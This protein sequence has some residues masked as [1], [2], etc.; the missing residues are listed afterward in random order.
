MF[1]THVKI[2][3]VK[4]DI[5][6]DLAPEYG[7]PDENG[8]RHIHACPFFHVG[9]EF[10]FNLKEGITGGEFCEWAK[11]AIFSNLLAVAGQGGATEPG[12]KKDI[13]PHICCCTDGLRPV[14]FKLEVM[15]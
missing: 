2:T 1:K 7:Q 14:V 9:D 13:P 15:E 5:F 3:V 4:A 8:I 6:E 11:A 10:V 12:K